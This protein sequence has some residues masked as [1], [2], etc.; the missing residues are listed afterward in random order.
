MKNPFNG[1]SIFGDKISSDDYILSTDGLTLVKWKNKNINEL[2]MNHDPRLRKVAFIG[3]LAFYN[4][5]NLTGIN[6]PNSVTSIGRQAFYGCISLTSVNIPN[7]VTSIGKE[8]FADC[9]SLTSITIPSSLTNFSVWFFA[10]CRNLTSIVFK[11]NNPPKILGSDNIFWGT[12]K[13]IVPKG[14]ENAYIK[15]GYPEGNL[16]ER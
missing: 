6:I 16:I 5:K 7:S 3:E 14:A 8:A 9:E 2:D 15:A 10:G 12:L 13:I 4:C 1:M 11:G